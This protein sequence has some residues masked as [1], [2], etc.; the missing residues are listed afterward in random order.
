MYQFPKDFLWGSS[1]SGPQ[2]AVSY[3]HLDVYKRQLWYG[4]SLIDTRDP[5]ESQ[6]DGGS[7]FDQRSGVGRTQFV[8]EV[9]S[10]NIT[11]FQRNI[12]GLDK[13]LGDM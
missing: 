12:N 7:L 6:R 3:T 10:Q 2:T 8:G 1:T 5:E 13:G 11:I 9:F 4:S